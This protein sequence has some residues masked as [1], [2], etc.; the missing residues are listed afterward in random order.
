M[1]ETSIVAFIWAPMRD[2]T[3]DQVAGELKALKTRLQ[4]GVSGGKIY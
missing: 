2:R 1:F 4:L 3:V